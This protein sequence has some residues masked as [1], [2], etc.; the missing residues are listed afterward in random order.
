MLIDSHCHL[1]HAEFTHEVDAILDRARRAGVTGFLTIATSLRDFPQ[2][3]A[4]AEAHADVFCSVGV[5]P[6]DAATEAGVSAAQLIE[7]A[8]HPKVAGIGECGLDYFY[9]K[10]AKDVQIAT[11]RAHIAAARISGLP[12]I[13]HSRD[14]D[15]DM[16]EILCEEH[17][18]GAFTGVLH[19]FSSGP[20]LADVAVGL[21]FCIS[22]SGILTF[23]KTDALRAIAARLPLDCLLVETDAPYLAPVPMRG[24]RNEPAFVIETLAVLAANRGMDEAE[25]AAV[26]TANFSRLFTRAA[27]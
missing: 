18:Q 9:N 5:H 11:F 7:L 15:T 10:S 4:I 17:R 21:G 20:E 12:L 27:F 16:A 24:R 8:A 2:V 25:L 13:V 3:R 26:T 19:C 6:H 1:D 22:F 14:A 23:K